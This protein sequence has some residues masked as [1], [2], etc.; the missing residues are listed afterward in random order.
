HA[1][2][3][4][5]YG[6]WSRLIAL[7]GG[8]HFDGI[9]S[10]YLH[11][12]LVYVVQGALWDV[13]GFHEWIGRVWALLFAVVLV[14]SVWRIAAGDRGGA[15]AGAIAAALLICS[16]DVVVGAAAGLTDVPV[17]A[18]VALTGA[19][20]LAPPSPRRAAL[21]ALGIAVA[22]A[23]AGLAK[24]SAFFALA[25]LVVAVAIGPDPRARLVWRGLPIVA[26]AAAALVWDAVQASELGVGL[27]SFLQGTGAD[28]SAGVTT[29][30]EELNAQS[31]GSFIAGMEW[32]GPYLVLPMLFGL[33][34]AIARVA[35][36]RHRL[37]ATIAAPL[38]IVLS[39]L[40]PFLAD[41]GTGQAVGPWDLDRPV[42][43][44]ASLA[45][46]VPLV[47]ARDC[48]EDEAPTRAHLARMLVWALPPA[49]AW[50]A[51]APFQTRY[52]SPAWA[53]LYALV[54]AA[55]WTALRG[56]AARRPALGWAVVAIVCAV[57]FFDLR[58]LDGLGSRPDGSID[59][60]RTISA[61]GV[62]GWFDPDR[63]RAGADP[64]LAALRDAGADAL[65][66]TDGRLVSSDGRLGFYWPDRVVRAEP[67]T[68]AAVRPYAV[69]VVTQA[70]TGLTAERE[71][72]LTPDATGGRA[73]DPSFWPRCR[74]PRLREV[75]ERPG[76]FT[77]FAIEG[78]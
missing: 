38:A 72:R 42:A 13:L 40:L 63:A 16:P 12:P 56:S 7:D 10:G 77:V 53:P 21:L 39:W 71:R 50:I 44:V 28:V 9:G 74:D 58:N 68:C 27:A 31:R 15:L 5:I 61:L 34:Y 25:G 4:L 54:A 66:A 32:L 45:L 37:A 75:D 20:A 48:P 22:A 46:I 78:S 62:S 26:G 6:R 51:S 67:Q 35:G 55:L 24:P 43:V 30:Y 76:E 33:L 59:A 65:S 49:V 29:L 36:V 8:L 3:A 14:A 64:S 1:T 2:D 23:L 70:A 69:L 52:L 17:A 47:L 60:A 41:P 73:T 18:T 19:L 11:R 57:A